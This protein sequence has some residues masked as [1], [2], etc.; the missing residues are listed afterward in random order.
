MPFQF[1]HPY[2]LL[3]LPPALGWTLWLAWKSD[4]SLSG[5]RRP[6]ALVTRLI[7]VVALVLA[8]AGVQWRRPEDGMNVFFMLDRSDSVP[9]AQQEQ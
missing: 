1:S 7:V 3:L 8:I 2:W 4:A 9:S 5:W 6:A